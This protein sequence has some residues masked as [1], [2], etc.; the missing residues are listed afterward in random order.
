[1]PPCFDAYVWIR[2]DDRAALLSRFIEGYVDRADPGDPRFD[3]FVRTFV[4]EKP[5][6]G[7]TE[8]L[9]DLGRGE[10]GAGA[11]SLYVKA[12]GFYGAIITLT[13][14]GAVVLGLSLDDPTS[15]PEVERQA[16]ETLASMLAEFQA[17]A[18]IAGVELAPPQSLSEWRDDGL[19]MLRA[20]SV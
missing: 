10:G 5:S 14:E 8:A 2:P 13:E 12:R 19:V 7:D 9:A 16:A 15:D 18:G 20:G 3:S 6:P 4:A 1:M 17:T 11:F